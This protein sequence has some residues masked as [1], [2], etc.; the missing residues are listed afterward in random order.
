MTLR[1]APDKLALVLSLVP[2][3]VDAGEVSVAEAATHFGVSEREIREAVLLIAVSG[4]P[5]V[6]NVVLHGDM[7]DID[8]D[9]FEDD[10][11]ISLTNTVAIDETP[12]FSRAEISALIAGVQYLAGLPDNAENVTLHSL[13]RKLAQA[14]DGTES[15]IAVAAAGF[16]AALSVIRE[17]VDTGSSVQFRYASPDGR[18]EVRTVDPLQLESENG[19]WYLRG[20]CRDRDAMRVF[21]ID[22]MSEPA[23]SAQAAAVAPRSV[24]IPDTLFDESSQ[25]FDVVLE[26]DRPALGLLG[27]Y[28]RSANVPATGSPVHVRVRVAHLHGLKRVIAANASVMRVVSPPAAVALVH[29]WV[30][31]AQ[32]RYRVD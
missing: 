8:W 7:F 26:V 27:D 12:R 17:A 14:S 4:V 30:T 21:R 10:G 3:L 1:H 24:A 32:N 22:R 29:D 23:L 11:V 25:D 6:D 13:Q 15:T 31:A 18:N 28:L 5:S 2:Y 19:L 16:E 9:A 20:W